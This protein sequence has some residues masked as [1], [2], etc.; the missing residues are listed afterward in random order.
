M[1]EIQSGYTPISWQEKMHSSEWVYAWF[2]SGKGAGKTR[3]GIEELI[4]CAVEFP[5][6]RY[7]IGRKTLPS[8]KDS[9][10]REFLSVIPQE[11]IAE[12]NKAERNVT[13][14][15][16]SVFMGRPLDE[17]KKFES[18]EIAGGLV[19][20]V[21]EVEKE[22]IDTLKSRMR[23]MI[24]HNGKRTQPRYRFIMISNPPDEDH[25]LVDLFF[26]I[27]PKNHVVFQSTTFENQANLPEGYIDQ[28]KSI[29]SPEMQQRMIYGQLGKV[30]KGRPVFPQFT[31][32]NFIRPQE[33]DPK[34]PVYRC[35]DFGFNRPACVW[36]QFYGKQLRVL[37]EQ[38]GQ[39][40]YLDDFLRDKIFPYERDVL[41]LKDSTVY[42]A[43]CDPAGSQ[44]SD[45][46]RTSIEILND[47][48][49]SPIYRKTRIE[50]GIKALKNYLDTKEGTEPCFII[51]PRCQ[52]LI[53]AFRGGYHRL[54]GVDDPAK[55]GYY[56]HLVDAL[57]YGAVHLYKRMR[58]G[59]MEAT[60]RDT[61]GR[62]TYKSKVS[63]Y[64]R[65]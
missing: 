33:F 50:E 22:I 4:A 40:I 11:L 41:G 42:K 44:E 64:R 28:L 52:I 21:D 58:F 9:T 26:H 10:W 48:G 29:Y 1:I 18:I 6:T 56:D 32:G 14:T 23:Q 24:E 49:I 47:H 35:L 34:L 65:E 57:R 60:F 16:G 59:S 8:L 31:T 39:R 55:D 3:A 19:D 27:K 17:M 13:L 43:F 2:L 20:E 62:A 12:S 38:M 7:I 51:H 61:I 30:H 63:S 37:G 15:N 25:W 54:D 45:K 5:G 53:E 46:G 36:L